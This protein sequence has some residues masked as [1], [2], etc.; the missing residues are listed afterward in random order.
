MQY[1]LAITRWAFEQAFF[2]QILTLILTKLEFIQMWCS[3]SIGLG[4]V[5]RFPIL[6]QKN[7]G[8]AFII[9]FVIMLIVEGKQ[10][11]QQQL[12]WIAIRLLIIINKRISTNDPP[13]QYLP[14]WEKPGIP[15]FYLEL[16]IG[17]RMRKAAIS[18]WNLVSPFAA[19]I[20]I[21]SA[22]V[23]FT[24][25]LY[26]NTMVAWTLLYLWDTSNS[27]NSTNLPYSH[28][29]YK[30]AQQAKVQD[31]PSSKSDDNA[32]ECQVSSWLLPRAIWSLCHDC[33]I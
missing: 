18:C 8:L 13:I 10:Q 2:E 3:Y 6:V 19:G 17:Q 7:G 20:G 32:N 11:Q 30:W 25:G 9:P 29:H 27:S 33:I 28:C 5:I 15:L 31:S 22:M 24:I 21:A 16:A 1:F 26:Y 23:S 12:N 14:S 4:N